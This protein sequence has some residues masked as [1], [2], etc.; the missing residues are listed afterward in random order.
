[1]LQRQYRDARIQPDFGGG[2]REVGLR[3]GRGKVM[4]ARQFDVVGG[5]D[6]TLGD[7]DHVVAQRFGALG[8]SGLIGAGDTGLPGLGDR[9]EAQHVR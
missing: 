4:R 1:M 2:S 5:D 7:R 9:L 8:H 6:V 3:H